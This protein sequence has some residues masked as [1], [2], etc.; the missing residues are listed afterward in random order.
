MVPALN[1][2]SGRCGLL[3]AISSTMARAEERGYWAA[4]CG[5]EFGNRNELFWWR[6]DDSVMETAWVGM[7]RIE[8][9]LARGRIFRR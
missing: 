8:L 4:E 6:F 3:D 1:R 5:N 9:C 2:P 7:V